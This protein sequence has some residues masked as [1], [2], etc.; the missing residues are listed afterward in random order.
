MLNDFF[1]P[2]NLGNIF[3][4]LFFL[5][6]WDISGWGIITQIFRLHIPGWLR[7]VIWCAGLGLEVFFLFFWHLIW[8]FHPLVIIVWVLAAALPFFR[9]YKKIQFSDLK[10]TFKKLSLPILM[11]VTLLPWIWIKT[12]LPPYLWDEMAYHY[13]SPY[14]LLT[15]QHWQFDGLYLNLPRLLDTGYTLLFTV[16]HTY[17]SARL[18]HLAIY[19]SALACL[20]LFLRR[21]FPIAAVLSFAFLT[22]G[23]MPLLIAATTG[24]VDAAAAGFIILTLLLLPMHPELAAVF[25]GLAV[26]TKYNTVLPLTLAVIPGLVILVRSHRFRWRLLLSIL[27]IFLIFGGYWYLKNLILF[28][29]PIY[30]LGF[31]SSR[32]FFLPGQSLL[33]GHIYQ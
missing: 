29:N 26:G 15:E 12:S 32:Q 17:A 21:S 9:R 8:P 16:T 23:Q 2:H 14:K 19:L 25:A 11:S 18:M 10:Q 1:A 24:Y 30:P 6:L 13:I 3:I 20:Y 5:F 7:P 28:G 33:I 4:L 31:T 22:F 27:G